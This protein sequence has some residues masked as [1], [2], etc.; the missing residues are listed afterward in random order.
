MK[1]YML[2]CGPISE[3]KVGPAITRL[4]KFLPLKS[5]DEIVRSHKGNSDKPA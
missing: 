3:N 1:Q 2:V 5:V 4:I